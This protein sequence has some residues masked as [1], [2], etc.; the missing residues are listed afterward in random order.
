MRLQLLATAALATALVAATPG[1]EPIITLDGVGAAARLTPELRS[2]IAPQVTALNTALEKVVAAHKRGAAAPHR[3]MHAAL[4]AAHGQAAGTANIHEA[5]KALHGKNA[6]PSLH[7]KMKAL[8]GSG[9]HPDELHEAMNAVHAI[10]EQLD[11]EQRAAFIQYLH[12]QL[13]A[14]GVSNPHAHGAGTH[15]HG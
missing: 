14:A 7:E 13:E 3:Q 15:S 8:H 1:P 10:I 6:D 9:D 5:L 4:K 12:A 11:P 2:A